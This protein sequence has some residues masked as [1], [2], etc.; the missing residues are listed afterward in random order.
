MW[1]TRLRQ[2]LR[3][4]PWGTGPSEHA[5]PAFH[6]PV[7]NKLRPQSDDRSPWRTRPAAGVTSLRGIA[8]ALNERGIPTASGQGEWQSPRVMRVLARL[9]A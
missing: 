2:S 1:S 3:V 8:A 6:D 7:T 9:S 4:L 5:T